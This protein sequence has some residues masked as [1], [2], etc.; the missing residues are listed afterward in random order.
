MSDIF[1]NDIDSQY[2]DISSLEDNI[3]YDTPEDDG[4]FVY[5]KPLY[6][7]QLEY[8]SEGVYAT[9]NNPK[10]KIERGKNVIIPT[11][12]GKDMALVLGEST[13]PV[14]IKPSDVVVIDRVAT[15]T[16]LHRAQE[17][18][19]R[20]KDAFPIFK[21]KV[22]ENGFDYLTVRIYEASLFLSMLPLHIDN[23]HKVFGFILNV[24]RILK[25]IEAD[26]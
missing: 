15:E 9:V 26:V 1:E 17:F 2:E 23:P 19:K 3:G 12:Y 22:Q 20:E 11:R 7:L 6:K 21:E 24:D 16:D 25:E 8:S 13:T 18:K 10:L 14:G 4:S 5:P